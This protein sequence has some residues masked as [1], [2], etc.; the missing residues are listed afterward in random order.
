MKTVTTRPEIIF[1]NGK[2][3]AVILKIADYEEMLERLEDAEDLRWL[4]K[5]RENPLQFRKLEDIL[6]EVS[7][8]V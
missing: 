3:S 1:K 7:V 4:K 8:G 2:P 6:A 5:A